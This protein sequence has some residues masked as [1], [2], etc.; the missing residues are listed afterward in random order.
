VCV[1]VSVHV[2][3][4]VCM[5]IHVR[6]HL[7]LCAW[8]G[9]CE[10]EHLFMCVY[11]CLCAC[12]C[13][14]VRIHFRLT[15]CFGECVCLCVRVCVC[16]TLR[17]IANVMV[18]CIG[19]V[20]VLSLVCLLSVACL[21]RHDLLG[22]ESWC[23]VC[24]MSLTTWFVWSW[25]SWCVV[26]IVTSLRSHAF[27]RQRSSSLVF[28]FQHRKSALLQTVC[29]CVCACLS[30]CV[31][32]YSC[33]CVHVCV[34]AWVGVCEIFARTFL[35]VVYTNLFS[36]K[37]REICKTYYSGNISAEFTQN[38]TCSRHSRDSI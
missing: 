23:V 30:L 20:C 27:A 10:R 5:C 21:W 13:L 29:V 31:Y 8:V 7:R 1:Y 34:C 12:L 16:D 17:L 19:H 11:M 25:I 37:I 33:V 9:V 15:D 2:C 35:I 38:W 4:Y 14:C 24:G 18:C 22:R 26:E 3:H 6:V 36:E 32:V 28:P